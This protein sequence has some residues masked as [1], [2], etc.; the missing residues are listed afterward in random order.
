M[1]LG[2]LL[3]LGIPGPTL[4]SSSDPSSSVFVKKMLA[5]Q[6]V[7]KDDGDHELDKQMQQL[8]AHRDQLLR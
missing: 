7:D 4:S 8:R 6:P 2:D 5:G 1:L 3:K